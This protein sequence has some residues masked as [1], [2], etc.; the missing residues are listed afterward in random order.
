MILPELKN[1]PSSWMMLA[2]NAIRPSGIPA[3]QSCHN[4]P[5]GQ[6]RPTACCGSCQLTRARESPQGCSWL[7]GVIIRASCMCRSRNPEHQFSAS[8]LKKTDARHGESGFRQMP[9]KGAWDSSLRD[10]NWPLSNS[11]QSYRNPVSGVALYKTSVEVKL[12]SF[13]G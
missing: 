6:A 7:L 2:N 3:G 9:E 11:W 5:I 13:V 1:W 12:P 4:Q 8:P 10:P